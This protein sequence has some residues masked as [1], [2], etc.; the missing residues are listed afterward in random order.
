MI[1]LLLLSAGVCLLILRRVYKNLWSRN[2]TFRLDFDSP[3]DKELVKKLAAVK[4]V[5][6]VRVIK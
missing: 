1:V 6:R 5:Y 4:D 3:A 2:L